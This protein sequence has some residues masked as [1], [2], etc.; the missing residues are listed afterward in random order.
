MLDPLE[1][2]WDDLLSRQPTLVE[3]AFIGLTIDERAWVIAHL[4]KMATEEDWH[5][6]QRASARTALMIIETIRL[7]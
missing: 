2:M 3:Q 5:P 1:Q 4:K 6:E 7:E